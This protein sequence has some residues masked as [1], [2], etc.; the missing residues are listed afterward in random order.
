MLVQRCGVTRALS[1]LVFPSP[2]KYEWCAGGGGELPHEGGTGGVLRVC[3][4][5]RVGRQ[6]AAAAGVPGARAAARHPLPRP[7]RRPLRRHRLRQDDA[8]A[9]VPARARGRGRPRRGVPHHLHA[10][11]PNRGDQR[12][13]ARRA[14]A[15]RA[16]AGQARQPSRV[17]LTFYI[18]L[19][20]PLVFSRGHVR[21][22]IAPGSRLPTHCGSPA[23]LGLHTALIARCAAAP[24]ALVF[25]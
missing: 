15:W 1:N 8:G 23:L 13:G 17:R 19:S 22:H 6:A 9:A 20:T 7:L 11:A 21:H 14:G 12:C 24:G 2:R 18:V 16:A 3:H 25:C 4:G 5:P 10:A